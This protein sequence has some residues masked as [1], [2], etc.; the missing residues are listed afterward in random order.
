M[1]TIR[2]ISQLAALL[3]I[4]PAM[5]AQVVGPGYSGINR[6]TLPGLSDTILSTPFAR[7]DAAAGLALSFAGNVIT[8]QGS[9]GWTANQF[10][11]GGAVLAPQPRRLPIGIVELLFALVCLSSTLGVIFFD[12]FILAFVSFMRF[13]ENSMATFRAEMTSFVIVFFPK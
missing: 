11:A 12:V 2:F 6:I 3:L 7:P 8:F 5:H 4:A 1:K 9:P 10:V 13:S